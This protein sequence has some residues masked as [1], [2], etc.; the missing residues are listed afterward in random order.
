VQ[1]EAAEH[2]GEPNNKRTGLNQTR[3][4]PR[5][6]IEYVA[7]RRCAEQT[8]LMQRTATCAC[9]KLWVTVSGEPDRVLACNCRECQRRT[10][11]VFGVAAYFPEAQVV[12]IEGEPKT[13]SR[14]SGPLQF[15]TSFCP[16]CGTSVLW[17]SSA[18]P[19]HIAIAVGCF[20]D[21]PTIVASTSEQHGWVRF[22]IG[23]QARPSPRSTNPVNSQ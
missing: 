18:L 21:P 19:G 9:R 13:F 7:P 2:E 8:V 12:S 11:S 22:P 4:K 6:V 23:L 5:Q 10:G 14:M 3:A 15:D 17:R 20:A 1:G 16:T